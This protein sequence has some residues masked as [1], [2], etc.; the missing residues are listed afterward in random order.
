MP[1]Y[2]RSSLNLIGGKA[3]VGLVGLG[4]LVIIVAVVVVVAVVAAVSGYFAGPN[5]DNDENA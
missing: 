5:H 1:L 3:M 2:I 4:L